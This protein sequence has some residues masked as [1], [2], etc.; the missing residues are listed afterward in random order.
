MVRRALGWGLV[1][2]VAALPVGAELRV[3]VAKADIT[4]PL[5]GAMYG[6]GARGDNVSTGVHDRLWGKVLVVAAG[7]SQIALV[8]LDLGAFEKD[9]T[10]RVVEGV[11]AMTGIEQTLLIASHSHS[12]PT[13]EPD[14]PAPDAPYARAAEERIVQAVAEAQGRLAPAR[15]AVG[16]GRVEEGHNRRHVLADGSVEMMWGNRER[17]PTSPVDYSLAVI[18]FDTPAGEPVATLINFAC[19]PVVL[20]PENLEFSADYPGAMMARVEEAT[21]AQAMFVQG[22]AGDINPFWDKT[23]PSEGAFEQVV[24]MGEKLAAEVLRV[25]GA[26]GSFSDVERLSLVSEEVRLGPRW[27]LEAP[28]VEQAFRE[29]EFGWIF[30]RY[31]ERFRRERD[32]EINTLLFDDRLAIGTFPGE[33]FVEHGMRFKQQSMVRD[34]IFAGYSNGMLGYFPTIRAAAEGGYGGKEATIVEVGAADRLINRALVHLHHQLGK[35]SD[36]PRF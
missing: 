30:E 17:K 7:E 35:L 22:A 29:N 9:R 28:A 16:W 6:Y 31:R 20:G 24:A 1:A 10:R 12:S 34:T 4:P 8:T 25:R 23:P 18:A 33:F 3:G 26:L 32:A 15:L 14:F 2:M 19:H 27:D 11:R 36:V 5:G 21:G 13:Y